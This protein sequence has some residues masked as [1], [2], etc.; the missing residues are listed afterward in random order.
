MLKCFINGYAVTV[1]FD[2]GSQVS[3]ID[4]PWRETFIPNH[5]VRP[6]HELLDTEESLTLYAA[7][8]QPIPYD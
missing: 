5:P 1:L 8:G 4:R 2:S 6:L 3:M 7:N